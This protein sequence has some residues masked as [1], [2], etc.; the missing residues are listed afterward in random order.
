MG[1]W[2][3]ERALWLYR[4]VGRVAPTPADFRIRVNPLIV[5]EAETKFQ[6]L[7]HYIGDRRCEVGQVNGHLS[8]LQ[9]NIVTNMLTRQRLGESVIPILG[10][11]KF[12]Y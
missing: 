6:A 8:F 9:P 4:H 3:A 7:A 1:R 11:E 2:Q 5:L 10:Y 12:P